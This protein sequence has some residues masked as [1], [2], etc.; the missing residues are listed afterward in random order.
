MSLR[1]PDGASGELATA[2]ELVNKALLGMGRHENGPFTCQRFESNLV[3]LRYDGSD[4]T[5][6]PQLARLVSE[7]GYYEPS[8]VQRDVLAFT[9]RLRPKTASFVTK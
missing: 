5:L 3:V 9:M 1:L 8:R 6:T 4:A 7:A 2:V